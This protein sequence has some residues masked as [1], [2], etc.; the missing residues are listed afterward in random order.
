MSYV[1]IYLSIYILDSRMVGLSR[2]GIPCNQTGSTHLTNEYECTRAARVL[3][4]LFAA[5]ENV[6][7]WPKGCYAVN[8]YVYWNMHETG[9]SQIG[10]A[11]EI[12][13][14]SSNH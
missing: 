11:Q 7:D 8:S 2:L 9:G 14:A 4:R 1:H 6:A 12:C 13:H 5:V 10:K 3:N